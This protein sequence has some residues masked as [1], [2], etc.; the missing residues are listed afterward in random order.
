MKIVQF[1]HIVLTVQSIPLT[2]AFYE[3]V[4]GLQ[5]VVFEGQ[6]HALHFGSQKINLHSAGNEYQPHA[7]KPLPGSADFCFV[8]PGSIEDVVKH[9]R[10]QDVEIEQGPVAQ[11]GA[12]GMMMSVY[13]RD[14]DGNLIEIAC[15]Q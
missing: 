9:L 15:Y 4:F 7:Q 14:P 1:D 10:L 6:H 2:V 12:A 11:T 8:A 3:K 13:F 5:H